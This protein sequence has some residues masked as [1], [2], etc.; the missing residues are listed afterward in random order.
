[1]AIKASAQLVR[2]MVSMTGYLQSLPALPPRHRAST[3]TQRRTGARP[4]RVNL[5]GLK[6]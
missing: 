4:S 2:R 3:R 1:M 5:A 6:L